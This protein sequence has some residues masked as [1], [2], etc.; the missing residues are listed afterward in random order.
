M[1]KLIVQRVFMSINLTS[2]N[3]LYIMFKTIL[4]TVKQE[5][6]KS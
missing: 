1:G 3:N 6:T 2:I 4:K 5:K